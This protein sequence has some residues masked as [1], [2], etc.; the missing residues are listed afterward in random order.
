M[1]TTS[2]DSEL[3]QLSLA[4]IDI[5]R[6]EVTKLEFQQSR[7]DR[8]YSYF[9]LLLLVM[10]QIS[11][12]WQNFLISTTYYFQPKGEQVGDPKY[13]I[14][15]SIPNFTDAKYGLL[16]GPVFYF[17]LGTCMLFA[18]AIA[19]Q[20]NRRLVLGAAS[21][22][23]ATSSLGTAITHTFLLLCTF[24]MMLGIFE[25]FSAPT[26]YSLIADYFP[27]E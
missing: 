24:R 25:S 17:F 2:I 12:Q 8:I 19:N 5:V 15:D 22:C 13:N 1:E 10:I 3:L 11:S 18:G 16:T 7:S 20:Y 14:R 4:E 27:P 21:I 23:W 26:S 6:V 9:V